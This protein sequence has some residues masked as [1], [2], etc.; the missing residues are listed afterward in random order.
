MKIKIAFVGLMLLFSFSLSAQESPNK[1]LDY[2][3]NELFQWNYGLFTGLT[4]SFQNQTAS[5]T[6]LFNLSYD[7]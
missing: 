3:D 5:T 2:Y 7:M 6:F 4:L 1:F